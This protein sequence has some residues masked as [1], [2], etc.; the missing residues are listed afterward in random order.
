[1]FISHPS[2]QEVEKRVNKGEWSSYLNP[3][4]VI[5][6]VSENT[7][8][9]TSPIKTPGVIGNFDLKTKCDELGAHSWNEEHRLPF[10][11]MY[12]I[13]ESLQNIDSLS[14]IDQQFDQARQE[15]SRQHANTYFSTRQ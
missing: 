13:K 1:M 5:Q 8:R 12:E 7:F 14:T 10:H 6:K 9:Q 4:S 11:P 15:R 2:N 3:Q